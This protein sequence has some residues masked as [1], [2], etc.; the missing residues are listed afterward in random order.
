MLATL[1]IGGADM[2]VVIS[3]YNAATGLAVGLEGFVLG[4]PALM[5]AGMV[6]GA[7]GTLLTLLMAKAMNRSVSNVLFTN[8][9]EAPKHKPSHI[10]GSLK[11]TDAAD[12][13]HLHA[14]CQRASSSCRATASPPRRRSRSSTIS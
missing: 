14:L 2:P 6:V 13:G 5:I 9:G 1:P 4:N 11:P 7:A 12:A 10:K 3:I 8:F